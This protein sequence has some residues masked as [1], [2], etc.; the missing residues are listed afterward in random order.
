LKAGKPLLLD[1]LAFTSGE[2]LRVLVANLQ[3]RSEEVQLSAL[4]SGKG[5]LRR[6]NEDTFAAAVSDPD[7]FLNMSETVDIDTG[8]ALLRLRAYETAFLSIV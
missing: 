1:G 4:P 8:E 5:S 7:A 2:T 3:P 6:L